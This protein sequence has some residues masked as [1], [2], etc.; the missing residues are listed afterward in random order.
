MEM[1]VFWEIGAFRRCIF[2]TENLKGLKIK[3]MNKI[4][5][6]RLKGGV[7]TVEINHNYT[8]GNCSR[9][10]LVYKFLESRACN[11]SVRL[12]GLCLRIEVDFSVVV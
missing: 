11:F 12:F 8:V 7:E 5:I 10:S 3:L 1:L 6:F 2:T 9:I 4:T